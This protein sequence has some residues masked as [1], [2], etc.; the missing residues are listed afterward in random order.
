MRCSSPSRSLTALRS[1]AA[2]IL[3]AIACAASFQGSASARRLEIEVE[4]GPATRYFAFPSIDLIPGGLAPSPRSTSDSGPGGEKGK[5]NGKDKHDEG[6]ESNQTQE[7]APPSQ[8]EEIEEERCW[9]WRPAELEFLD[10]INNARTSRGR[11]PVRLDRELSRV[12]RRHTWEMVEQN[13]LYHSPEETLRKRVTNWLILGEN[14]GR[15]GD[16]ESL[17]RAFMASEPHR[18]NLLFPAFNFVGIGTM[19]NERGLWVTILLEAYNDPGTT[20]NVLPWC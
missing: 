6:S 18:D 7:G 12:A 17:H 9:Q 5:G 2:L 20:L 15:G 16:A 13:L 1:I 8:A 19:R 14:L 10:M 11:K 4:L 3:L